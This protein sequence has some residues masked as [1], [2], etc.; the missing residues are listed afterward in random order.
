VNINTPRVILLYEALSELKLKGRYSVQHCLLAVNDESVSICIEPNQPK[1]D[2]KTFLLS[3]I[4]VTLL[5][6]FACVTRIM[7]VITIM[8]LN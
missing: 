5:N 8:A 7:T 1:F 6:Y 4:I 2:C 3:D